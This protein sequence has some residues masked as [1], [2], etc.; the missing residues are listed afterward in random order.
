MARVAVAPAMLRWAQDRAG[1]PEGELRHKFPRLDDW[2]A[3]RV[4]PT[5]RQLEGFARATM[6]PFGY[7]FLPEPPEEHLPI[8]HYRTLRDA[9]IR[10]PSPNLLET[11]QTQQRRQA[12]MRETLTADGEERLAFVGSATATDPVVDVARD[13]RDQLGIEP[14]WAEAHGT[15][16]DAL[17]ALRVLIDASGIVVATNGVVGNNTHRKLDAN[18]FRGFVLI[19]EFAPFVFVNGADGKAAQMFTLA[20]ELAHVWLGHSAAFDLKAMQ[21]ADNQAEL[22]CNAVAAEFLL[23]SHQLERAWLEARL[24][25]DPYQFVARRFKVSKIVAA[26]RVLDLGWI[27]RAEFFDF[28]ERYEIDENRQRENRPD[29]G[30]F[31]MS[32]HVRLGRRFAM[33]VVQAVKD[34]R[35]LYREAYDLTGLAGGTFDRYVHEIQTTL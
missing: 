5:F 21:P 28:Y 32:Q 23:P 26:R 35:L 19:D 13:I 22:F 11:V 6:T 2:E 31:Y 7:F 17:R 24:V 9:A 18:E 14:G 15:W 33:T 10:R 16:T 27:A 25:A 30:D 29:G 20:H 34:G 1:L 4:Q 3:Q 12:W 8:P